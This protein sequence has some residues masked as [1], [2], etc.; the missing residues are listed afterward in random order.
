MCGAV[1]ASCD[2]R[3]SRACDQHSPQGWSLSTSAW[4]LDRMSMR[5]ALDTRTEIVYTESAV[6]P[7]NTAEPSIQDMT[8]GL[9]TQFA[10]A[11]PCA[12][13]SS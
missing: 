6:L 8:H 4:V 7:T 12:M 1:F 9:H 2:A 11:S 3:P 5:Q 10:V 13:T